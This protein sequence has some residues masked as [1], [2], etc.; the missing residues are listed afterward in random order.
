M[1]RGLWQLVR[2]A[3]VFLAALSVV[4]GAAVAV[5]VVWGW[6][7]GLAALS[8]ALVTGAGNALND[9]ADQSVD[10]ESKS[11][12]PIPRGLV[13]PYQAVVLSTALFA[14]GLGTAA[15]LGRVPFFIAAVASLF[16]SLYDT[17][18]KRT[19]L[20]GNVVVACLGG[21][22]F[23]YGGLVAGC[24]KAA[25]VPAVFAAVYHLGRELV[26]DAQDAVADR[27]AGY[28]TLAVV[29]GPRV[30]GY[31]AALPLVAIAI[32][33]PYPYTDWGYEW[34]YLLGAGP[35]V[36]L[37]LVS[38]YRSTRAVTPRTFGRVSAWLKL[39]ML[40]ALLSFVAGRYV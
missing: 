37:V 26:K 33:A 15:V 39:G 10:L 7:L 20:V 34:P 2:P 17:W 29:A 14:A 9:A 25:A 27:R 8:A 32:L 4:V 23:I 36:V 5:D 6:R 38:A 22:T 35:L 21:L 18:F 31:L 12:R 13:S 3:N 28:R 40:L 1:A 24:V 11:H 16:L 30:A 19:V